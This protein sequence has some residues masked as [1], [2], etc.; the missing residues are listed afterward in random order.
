MHPSDLLSS[1]HSFL[2]VA[3]DSW[4]KMNMHKSMVN[5]DFLIFFWNFLGFKVI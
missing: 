4:I 3:I 5:D 1:S 2:S